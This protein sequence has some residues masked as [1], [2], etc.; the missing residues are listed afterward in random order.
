MKKSMRV[1]YSK[2]FQELESYYAESDMDYKIN[3]IEVLVHTKRLSKA[4]E[5]MKE[6]CNQKLTD[7][8]RERLN[9][10]QYL[11]FIAKKDEYN[12]KKAK[13]EIKKGKHF[14]YDLLFEVCESTIFE[15]QLNIFDK[16]LYSDKMIKKNYSNKILKDILEQL[17]IQNLNRNEDFLQCNFIERKTLKHIKKILNKGEMSVLQLFYFQFILMLLNN[18]FVALKFISDETFIDSGVAYQIICA[19]KENIMKY[20]NILEENTVIS[21][22]ETVVVGYQLLSSRKEL[23]EKEVKELSDECS[24][25]IKKNKLS[26]NTIFMSKINDSN[27]KVN[28]KDFIEQI[29]K[30]MKGKNGDKVLHLILVGASSLR[31]DKEF[32]SY[33]KQL[34]EILNSSTDFESINV[35]NLKYGILLVNF[36]AGQKIDLN[37]L[38]KNIYLSDFLKLCINY[39]NK[40]INYTDF[41]KALN[42]LDK[43]E[44][45]MILNWD[46]LGKIFSSTNSYEWLILILNKMKMTELSD[47]LVKKFVSNAYNEI[48]VKNKLVLLDN[49]I[50]FDN[51]IRNKYD[52]IQFKYYAITCYINTYN[53]V[54]DNVKALITEVLYRFDEL[55]NKLSEQKFI[56]G[57]LYL[58]VSISIEIEDD[59]IRSILIS[60]V[61][62]GVKDE[63]RFIMLYA[64]IFDDKELMT[65]YY[66][67]IFDYILKKY[68]DIYSISNSKEQYT[69]I[70]QISYKLLTVR[71][72][73]ELTKNRY[74]YQNN[75]PYI[76]KEDYNDELKK[77]YDSLNFRIVENNP[78][79]I[80]F[81]NLLFLLT[82]RIFF[83]N[84]EKMKFGKIIKTPVNADGKELVDILLK[85]TGYLERKKE[86]DRIRNGE[87]IDF[88]WFNIYDLHKYF[89]DV[90]LMNSKIFNLAK[91]E[92]INPTKKIIHISSLILLSKL[93]LNDVVTEDKSVFVTSSVYDELMKKKSL[94]INELTDGV[95]EPLINYDDLFDNTCAIVE[96][97]FEQQQV[98]PVSSANILGIANMNAINEYDRDIFKIFA[99]MEEQKNSYFII[100]ED[101]YYYATA[102]FDKQSFGVYSYIIEKFMNHTIDGEKLL[103]IT[104]KLKKYNYKFN[105]TK[106]L[107]AYLVSM[108][109][110]DDVCKVVEMLKNIE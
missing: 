76:L 68:N 75:E 21:L 41:K 110:D 23:S 27:S 37:I 90:E 4:F 28:L 78:E 101:P 29:S 8:Q 11:Y 10:L 99:T 14:N 80:Q 34:E 71:D 25:F 52:D 79:N 17:Y 49:F 38:E 45:T 48:L 105:I 19:L 56:I 61:E 51:E 91:N 33:S 46:R 50:Y 107:F 40:Q 26:D 30:A 47:Y 6:C 44:S 94:D 108:A 65:K 55:K 88:V 87:K 109:D 35:D 83:A 57:F 3:V 20:E 16:Y 63:E 58:L 81:D 92:L 36:W 66:D 74:F 69:L 5:R 12:L 86:L 53:F 96:K 72:K 22:N 67:D 7:K 54:D 70:S 32:I 42:N 18:H 1:Y 2:T 89:K 60:V 59:S 73:Y 103:D 84:I 104:N 15:E 85:E 9:F 62:D 43:I 39:E 24:D 31:E 106:N 97:L 82:S 77:I 102:G 64:L 100:T 98:I 93:G 13:R 95:V